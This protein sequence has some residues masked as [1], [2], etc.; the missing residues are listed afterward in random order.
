MSAFAIRQIAV[1]PEVLFSSNATETVPVW[2]AGTAYAEKDRSRS[3]VTNRIYESLVDGNTAKDPTDPANLFPAEGAV[4]LDVGP[5]NVW[6]MFDDLNG[7][8]T[9]REGDLEVVL[10][11]RRVD[12]IGF[13]GLVGSSIR[14]RINDGAED[15][16]DRT[17]SLLSGPG[18]LGWWSWFFEERVQ[19]RTLLLT[20]LPTI[21]AP[22]ITV[23]LI[24]TGGPVQIGTLAIGRQLHIGYTEFGLRLS[25]RSYSTLEDAD[26]GVYKVKKR[27]FSRRIYATLFVENRRVNLIMQEL[28]KLDAVPIFWALADRF[29]G[30]TTLGYY[31]RADVVVEYA[32]HSVITLDIEGTPE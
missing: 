28:D 24:G 17:F 32:T 22:I 26:I 12:S 2:N 13:G 29:S 8:A 31:R 7:T 19:R 6:A 23:T 10:T 20:D 9:V 16:Y 15:I 4:W 27:G 18:S 14:V 3:D 11:P 21:P 25:R 1:T 5:T 30:A